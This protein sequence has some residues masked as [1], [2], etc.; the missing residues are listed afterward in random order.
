CTWVFGKTASIASGSPWRPST[1][2]IK[3]S[4]TPR[5]FSSVKTEN[6]NFAPSLSLSHNPRSSF[7]PSMVMPKARYTAFVWT[8]PSWR[9][10]TNK[11]SKYRIGYTEASGRACQVRIGDGRN[12]R[13]RH[14]RTVE[15][16]QMALNVA[17]REATRIQTQDFVVKA[18]QAP[19]TLGHELRDE[20]P[21]AVT[22]DRQLQRPGVRLHRLLALAVARVLLLSR[23]AHL[24]GIA[25]VGGRL[26]LQ[27]ALN[28]PFGQL[29]E[30][31]LLPK[32]VSRVGI[33]FE[34][35]VYQGFLFGVYTGHRVLLHVCPH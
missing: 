31:P 18:L 33:I 15:L 3:Q 22:R 8:G 13:R 25:Q 34:Q 20:A 12:Q 19:L 35:F 7:S 16:F 11:A 2:A 4:C 6:Q 9:D 21:I 14:L 17:R 30:Q 10:F 23:M 29:L 5:F 24:R 1:H 32:D 26:S 27:H 28:Y